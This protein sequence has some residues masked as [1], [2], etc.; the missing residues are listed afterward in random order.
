MGMGRG[1]SGDEH[2]AIF[3]LLSGHSAIARTVKEIPDGVRTTTTTTEPEL[4]GT[5]RTHVRQMVRRL[6]RGRPVRMWDPVF[7][8][9]SP[10]PTRSP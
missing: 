4:V 1:M 9:C 7:R 8:G 3:D 10:T 6:E 5:L 2:D